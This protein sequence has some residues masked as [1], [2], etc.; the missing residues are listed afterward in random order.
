MTKIERLRMLAEA[1]DHSKRETIVPSGEVLWHGT[2]ES[3]DTR[4]PRPGGYDGVFWT[5]ENP[6]IARSYIPVSAGTT[7]ASV[8]HIVKEFT[9]PVNYDWKEMLGITKSQ[10]DKAWEIQNASY[11][12]YQAIE[13]Q[14]EEARRIRDN[15]RKECSDLLLAGRKSDPKFDELKKLM[16]DS[17]Q[18][19]YECEQK[20]KEIPYVS[21]DSVLEK[22]VALKLKA[23]GYKSASDNYFHALNELVIRDGK[24]LPADFREN[25]QLLKV[26]PKR[27]MRVYNYAHGRE[28]DLM[29]VDYHKIDLFRRLEKE[30]YDGIIINDFAQVEKRHNLSHVSVGFFKHAVKDL[31]IKKVRN[32]THPHVHE[33]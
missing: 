18:A 23:L 27:D 13:K 33:W 5:A 8:Y 12:K 22:L 21:Y 1:I 28:A 17:G 16:L 20:L 25:G 11:E 19:A 31:S 2:A 4:A 26:V 32:Q 14:L 3:F 9:R 7:Y 30:G 6:L 29:N 10:L 24:L 15:A